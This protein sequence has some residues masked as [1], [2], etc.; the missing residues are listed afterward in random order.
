[1]IKQNMLK[2]ISTFDAVFITLMA[3]CGLALKP[4]VGPFFKLIGS[5]LLI[6]SGSLAGAIY[7]IWPMLALLTVQQTG[8]ATFVG[9]L[10]G[11]IVL[12]TGIFGSHGV[13]SLI[14][15]TIPGVMIDIVYLLIHRI[16]NKWLMSLPAAMGNVSGTFIVGI[17]FMHIPFIL[18]IIGL[19]PA[20]I[21]GAIGGYLSLIL[22]KW[23][24]QT[25]PIL[26]K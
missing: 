6:P 7:M 3:A 8:T 18:L 11:I 12:V 13:L 24:V 21:F 26:K 17:V 22:Y 23:L 5:A 4:I 16:N 19:I 2:K 14:T 9:L 1:M 25:F 20:F 10:Q 15:Y